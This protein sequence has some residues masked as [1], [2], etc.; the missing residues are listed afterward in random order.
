MNR[1][2]HAMRIAAHGD[3]MAVGGW[4]IEMIKLRLTHRV[5]QGAVATESND[6]EFEIR[7][8]FRRQRQQRQQAESPRQTG[9]GD[10]LERGGR[11][12]EAGSWGDSVRTRE[13]V[14]VRVRKR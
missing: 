4:D 9:H 5:V 1:Q 14:L 10:S 7:N 8:G 13:K 11:V 12:V 6:I 3:I 2:V